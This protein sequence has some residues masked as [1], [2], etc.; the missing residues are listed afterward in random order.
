MLPH[1]SDSHSLT[2]CSICDEPVELENSNTEE[3]GLAVH[4]E[5]YVMK[6]QTEQTPKKIER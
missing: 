5:C 2:L 4:E 1:I 6:M 3:H